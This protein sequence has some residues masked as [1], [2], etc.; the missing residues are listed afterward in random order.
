MKKKRKHYKKTIEV[1]DPYED[2]DDDFAYIAGYTTAGFAYGLRWEDVG[3]SSELPF[4]EK[5]RL[6]DMQCDPGNNE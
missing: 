1:L 2:M 5:V 3:I 6:Y 4:E